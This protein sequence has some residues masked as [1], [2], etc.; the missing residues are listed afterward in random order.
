MKNL[1]SIVLGVFVLML[2]S[3]DPKQKSNRADIPYLFSKATKQIDAKSDKDLIFVKGLTISAQLRLLNDE[4]QELLKV[5]LPDGKDITIRRQRVEQVKRVLHWYGDVVNEAGS[6]VLITSTGKVAVGRITIGKKHYRIS[7]LGKELHQIAE[8]D[9]NKITDADDDAEVPKYTKKGGNSNETDGC[10]DPATDIDIM[11]VYTEDAETGAGGP[12]A[13]E[14]LI[15]E[16]V[17]LTNLAYLNCNITQRLHLVHF[18]KV[19]FTENAN[20]ATDREQL[21]NPTDGVIDEIHTWRDAHGADVVLMITETA[22]AGNCGRAF[23]MD[24]V[25]P[26]HEEFAFGVVKRECAADNLSFPHELGHIMSARH[27]DDGTTTPFTYCHGHF[28]TTPAD[29]SG[30]GWETMMSK[31]SDC[32]RQIFFS[33]PDMQFSPTGSA[34][35]DPMGTATVGDNHRVLNN[36]ASTVANFRCSSPGV[37]NVWM[38]DSWNDTGLEPDPATVSDAMWR[39]P[40]IWVRN[41]QDPTFLHQH[42]HE[43]P[44]YGSTN[45]IYVKMH[46]GNASSQTGNLKLYIADASASLAWPIAWSEIANIPVTIS[47]SSTQIIEQQWNTVPNPA[48]GSSHYCMVARWESA[49]DPMHT[50]EGTNITT[51]VRENNNIIWRNMNV[52]DLSDAA[53][54]DVALNIA[55]FNPRTATQIVFEDATRFPLPRWIGNGIVTIQIDS[56]LY[57]IWKENKG[58]MKGLKEIGNGAFEMTAKNASIGNLFIPKDYKGLVKVHFKKTSK[59]P[60]SKFEF[61]VK[62]YSIIDQQKVLMGGVDYELNTLKKK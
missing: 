13:M 54:A 18:A 41:S 14:A 38:K 15:Y 46:N 5:T 19:T 1:I 48:S 29:G 23:I 44:E 60:Q 58:T 3:C 21:K 42:E 40:Y 55:S 8:I 16:C 53:D 34:S 20:S 22:E 59:V 45:W 30:I 50:A 57:A 11:V 62:H 37:G 31:R 35:T 28:Q 32:D 4:N 2:T 36:T 27:H 12:E 52:V 25:D 51:N 26:S 6:F 17:E 10:P 9:L 61:S 7:F 39:S 43:N 49:S 24:P 56:K 47:G 33:N